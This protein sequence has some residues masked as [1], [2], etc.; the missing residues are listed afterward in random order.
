MARAYRLNQSCTIIRDT[1]VNFFCKSFLFSIFCFQFYNSDFCCRT[2]SEIKSEQRFCSTERSCSPR[3]YTMCLGGP[4]EDKF[5]HFEC[6]AKGY[7]SDNAFNCLNRIDKSHVLFKQPLYVESKP[8][9]FNMNQNLDFDEDGIH[10][11]SKDNNFTIKWNFLRFKIYYDKTNC[12]LI[13]G[14][15]IGWLKLWESLIRDRGF[16]GRQFIPSDF[17]KDSLV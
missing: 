12:H 8:R 11:N 13:D 17:F 9:G 4:N 1:R 14:K 16:K 3:W 7:F 5:P 15:E 6:Q 10:C 2:E